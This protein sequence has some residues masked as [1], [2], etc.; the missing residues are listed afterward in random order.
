MNARQRVGRSKGMLG[1]VLGLLGTAVVVG[2]AGAALCAL[3]ERDELVFGETSEKRGI[4]IDNNHGGRQK[5]L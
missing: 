4:I 1:D 2:P 5:E 3:W